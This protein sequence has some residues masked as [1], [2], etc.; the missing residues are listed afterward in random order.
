MVNGQS[1]P[2]GSAPLEFQMDRPEYD[3]RKNYLRVSDRG[4]KNQGTGLP[5]SLQVQNGIVVHEG[6]Y[7]QN[8]VSTGCPLQPYCQP[9]GMHVTLGD[10]PETDQLRLGWAVPRVYD[11]TISNVWSAE[12]NSIHES[13]WEYFRVPVPLVSGRRVRYTATFSNFDINAANGISDYIN[14]FDIADI[15]LF[16]N[17]DVDG[18]VLDQTEAAF[19]EKAA[20]HEAGHALGIAMPISCSRRDCH[21]RTGPSVM[22]QG[23]GVATTSSFST[24]D[25]SQMILK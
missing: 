20:L 22:R 10:T 16:N 11:Q 19:H 4:V 3:P 6:T 5:G 13:A 25:I 21:P 1:S 7:S 9:K 2:G 17:D 23:L 14:P 24:V 18:L 8:G 15:G 12:I